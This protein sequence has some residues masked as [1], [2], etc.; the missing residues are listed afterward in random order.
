MTLRYTFEHS[1]QVADFVAR[2]IPQVRGRGFGPCQAIGVLDE[3]NELIAGLV[4]HRLSPECGVIEL[5]AASLPGQQW[6]TRMTL[7]VAYQYPFEQC[8][9]QMVLHTTK[10]SNMRTQRQLASLGCML[11]T[12]PRL[13]GRNEDA[14]VCLLTYEDWLSNKIFQRI[15]RHPDQQQKEAA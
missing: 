14:V 7:R 5:S 9:C 4:Y 6:L 2:M 11:V 10:A 8:G 15:R 1:E 13:Y 3:D 12:M